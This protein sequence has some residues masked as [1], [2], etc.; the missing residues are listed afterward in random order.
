ML[1]YDDLSQLHLARETG[2]AFISIFLKSSID[3]YQIALKRDW[4]N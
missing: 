3:F 4:K 2:F 1:Q